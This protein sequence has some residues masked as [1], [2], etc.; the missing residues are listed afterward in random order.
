MA[1]TRSDGLLVAAI[2]LHLLELPLV[3]PFAA[4]HGT[5]RSRTVTVLRLTTDRGIGW[6]ECSALP[7]ATY[8]GESAIGSFELLA[9]AVGPKLLGRE[10]DPELAELRTPL[11]RHPM[12]LAALEM[13]LLDVELR[14]AGRSLASWLG[15]D[16]ADVPAG[17]SL[18]LDDPERVLARARGLG[19]EGYGRLKVKIQPGHDVEVV[20]A[21][22]DDPVLAAARVEIQVDA[23]GS[24]PPEALGTLVE[25]AELGVDAIE[26][27]FAPAEIEAA[28]CLV[29]ALAD[30][31]PD[32]AGG[33]PVPVVGDEA[34]PTVAAARR[35]ADRGAL[36]GVSIKP[37]RVGGLA[38][39]RE[40]H[41][42]CRDRGLAATAGGMLETGLGRHALAAVAA[43]PGF[44]LTGDL[45]PAGRWLAADPWPDLALRAGRILVP[46]GV[47]I[48]PDPDPDR[49]DGLTV[50]RE[51][52]RR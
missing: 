12:A 10:V 17:V 15:V 41:D 38:V 37:P 32:R 13:A 16:R 47:G 1:P 27:P 2:D 49:L 19:A 23:N 22:R 29:S 24:Y 11:R 40:L 5:T 52:L 3:E 48:A 42:L 36:S 21:L 14:A 8:S 43:L 18:G 33:R 30:R 4:A 50:R 9:G 26:Q 20:R 28:E 25:L 7:A 6:G 35:L 31:A 45:S 34:V 39:A 51:H 46:T 44:D